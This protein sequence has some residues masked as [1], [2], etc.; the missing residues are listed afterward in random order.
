MKESVWTNYTENVAQVTE[1]IFLSLVEKGNTHYL[2]KVITRQVNMRENIEQEML[3][4][5]R[6]VQWDVVTHNFPELK[7]KLEQV[8]KLIDEI[9]LEKLSEAIEG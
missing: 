2:W 5:L 1:R 6:D 9:M 7:E 3:D 8:I 4:K